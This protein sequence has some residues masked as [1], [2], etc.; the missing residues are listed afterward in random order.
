M[1]SSSPPFD[2]GS[3]QA[4]DGHPVAGGSDDSLVGDQEEYP[5]TPWHFKLLVVALVLYL[6]FRAVQLL[7]W[8]AERL[9]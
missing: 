4:A 6:G 8:L 7:V 3:G 2:S 1:A 5:P 9:F